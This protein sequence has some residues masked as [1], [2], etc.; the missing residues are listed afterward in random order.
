[1][2]SAMSK[3]FSKCVHDALFAPWNLAVRPFRVAPRIYYVGNVWVGSYL[4]DTEV[5]LILID[6]SVFETAHMLVDSIYQL[7]FDPHNIKHIMI[8]HFHF[9]HNGAAK[10]LR[11]LTGAKVWMSK[12][13]A[14]LRE[15]PANRAI[16]QVDGAPFNAAFHEVDCFYEEGKVMQFG[17]VT[18]QPILTPG[19]TPGAVSF[20][21]TVPDEKGGKLV[22]A[23]H[24]GVGPITMSDETYQA[25]GVPNL[26]PRFIADCDELKKIH[27]DIAIP[28]HPSHGNL[29]ER[30]GDDP[31]D[32]S[33]LIDPTEWPKFLEERKQFVIQLE[34][35]NSAEK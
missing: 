24:G 3:N 33:G 30:H 8:S 31:M 14:D 7:G 27:V 13:D 11:E 19:H 20:V 16:N 26:R 15:H 17:S 34:T 35:G 2:G 23:M 28:S 32:Y 5:G 22:A 21:I 29:F 18:I 4:V 6:C 10:A 12:T 9:D 25:L 1:M